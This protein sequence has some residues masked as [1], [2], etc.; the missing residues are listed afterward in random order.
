MRYP[1]IPVHFLGT[2]E[3][4]QENLLKEKSESKMD[5]SEHLFF[6]KRIAPQLGK[7]PKCNPKE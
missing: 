4:T 1:F 6:S 7:I 2:K 3:K 5:W